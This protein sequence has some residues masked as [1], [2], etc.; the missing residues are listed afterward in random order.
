MHDFCVC[1]SVMQ[2]NSSEFLRRYGLSLLHSH[3]VLLTRTRTCPL[4]SP[5]KPPPVP[6]WKLIR[7]P[8]KILVTAEPKSK[9]EEDW[10]RKWKM[11]R[12]SLE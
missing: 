10:N 12:L 1:V 4:E 2:A 11:L 8:K 9:L 5:P 3:A 7:P 6:S